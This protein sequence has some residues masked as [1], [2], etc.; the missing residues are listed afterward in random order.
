MSTAVPFWRKLLF[1]RH[2]TYESKLSVEAYAEAL[3]KFSSLG[4]E[5]WM[6]DRVQVELGEVSESGQPFDILLVYKPSSNY[7]IASQAKGEIVVDP[8]SERTVVR[9]K[10]WFRPSIGAFLAFLVSIPMVLLGLLY[11]EES[12]ALAVGIGI[13]MIII[14]L[15]YGDRGVLIRLIGDTAIL[16]PKRHRH[17]S[18][19]VKAK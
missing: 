13:P 16:G 15:A 11:P 1:T 12:W 14:G 7:F 4:S 10:V 19:T 18:K 2:F 3:E 6:A 8:T 5:F 9:G 17:K